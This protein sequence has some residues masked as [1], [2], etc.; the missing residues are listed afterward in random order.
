MYYVKNIKKWVYDEDKVFS[1]YSGGGAYTGYLTNPSYKSYLFN[2]NAPY[3]YYIEDKY[4][5]IFGITSIISNYFPTTSNF[6]SQEKKY[7]GID[8][9]TS[10]GNWADMFKMYLPKSVVDAIP[11]DTIKDKAKNYLD[12]LL[13]D[14]NFNLEVYHI[15]KPVKEDI[16]NT[17]FG[18]QLLNLNIEK[19][20]NKF[21][22]EDNNY[23]EV[24]LN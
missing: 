2:F 10:I 9:G 4:Q 3:T 12:S 15:I 11:G 7:Y 6:P 13:E 17:E 16:T 21:Y 5:K 14:P 18:Q 8:G 22:T 1:L 23:L 24:Q 20:I 19:G